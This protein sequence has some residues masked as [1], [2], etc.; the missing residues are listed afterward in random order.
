MRLSSECLSVKSDFCGSLSYTVLQ[1]IT[2]VNDAV[3]FDLQWNLYMYSGHHLGQ[4]SLAVIE[5]W[6]DHTCIV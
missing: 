4:R 2:V 1:C 3:T 6:P 5:R